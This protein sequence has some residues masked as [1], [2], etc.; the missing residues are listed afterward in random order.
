MWES[1]MDEFFVGAQ[2]MW[3]VKIPLSLNRKDKKAVEG[4]ILKII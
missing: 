4:K 3:R 2:K 1:K